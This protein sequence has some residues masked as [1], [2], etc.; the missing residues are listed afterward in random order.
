MT[1]QCSYEI[2]RRRLETDSG[3]LVELVIYVPVQST[4]G[5]KDWVCR[6][7]IVQAAETTT[8]AS[9]G[10]DSLQ[11][12]SLGLTSLRYGIK[13]LRLGMLSWGKLR[14]QTGLP[15]IVQELDED[16][17]DLM[18]NLMSAEQSRRAMWEK[19]MR[20]RERGKDK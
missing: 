18:Q 13:Q 17:Q 11:A 16:F 10:A 15:L 2:A 7:E 9:R 20:E 5:N 12:L 8:F 1:D 4:E 3:E 6:T 14:G 19:A